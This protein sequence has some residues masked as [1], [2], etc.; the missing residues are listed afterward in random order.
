[1][2]FIEDMQEMMKSHLD[3]TLF[4]VLLVTLNNG[5]RC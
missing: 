4:F 2:V 1:M 3:L 5:Q